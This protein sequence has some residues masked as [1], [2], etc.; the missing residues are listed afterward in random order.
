[1]EPTL[2]RVFVQKIA[3]RCQA[4]ALMVGHPA[5]DHLVLAPPQKIGFQ[6]VI[7]RFVEAI[8]GKPLSLCHAEKVLDSAGGITRRAR[9]LE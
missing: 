6:A 7:D 3:N 2:K 8:V 1:M 5:S 9:Q 4:H